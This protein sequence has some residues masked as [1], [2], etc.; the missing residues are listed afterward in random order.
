MNLADRNSGGR[1]K[2]ENRPPLGSKTR[3]RTDVGNSEVRDLVKGTEER[4]DSPSK[5]CAFDLVRFELT[6]GRDVGGV[7]L[8]VLDRHVHRPP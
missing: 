3:D 5:Y 1:G 8:S 7:F 4:N 6:K 2:Q